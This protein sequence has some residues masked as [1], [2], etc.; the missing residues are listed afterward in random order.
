M[1]EN[2]EFECARQLFLQFHGREPRNGEIS[3]IPLPKRPVVALEVGR[4]T[5]IGYERL[6]GKDFR[7]DFEAPLA[8]LYVTADG[9]QVFWTG[10]GYR[11]TRVG[12]V[13]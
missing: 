10:G 2:A 6:D 4:V 3:L 8:K 11:F 13:R 9:R 5:Q 1:S 7:H 12:F